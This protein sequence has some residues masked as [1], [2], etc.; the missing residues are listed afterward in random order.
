MT[1]ALFGFILFVLAPHHATTC[2]PDRLG[3]SS[4]ND[5]VELLICEETG[6]AYPDGNYAITEN[7]ETGAIVAAHVWK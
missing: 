2:N 6:I 7:P 4:N 5:G 3:I 1:S